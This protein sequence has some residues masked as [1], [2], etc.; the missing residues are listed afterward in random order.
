M[1]TE[2]HKSL[3]ENVFAETARG[4]GR[5]FVDALSDDV[6]WTVVGSTAWSRTYEGKRAVLKELLGPL[7][8]QLA[9]GNTITASR[10]IGEGDLV[11]VEGQGHNRTRT[12]KPYANTYCWLFRFQGDKVVEIT[13]YAD[14][15]LMESAL[16]P[17]N[18]DR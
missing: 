15:A 7:S 11:V 12:G 16:E 1:S 8:A 18:S 4:N 3:L 5:P 6:S 14:T 13:E 9:D 17:P 2:Q 10:F